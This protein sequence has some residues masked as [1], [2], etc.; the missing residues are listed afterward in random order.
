MLRYYCVEGFTNDTHAYLTCDQIFELGESIRAA[1]GDIPFAP[2]SRVE[3]YRPIIEPDLE[4]EPLP[5]SAISSK[6]RRPAVL[7]IVVPSYNSGPYLE[8]CAKHLLHQGDVSPEA[9]EVIFVDDGS[10]DNSAEMCSQL[11]ATRVDSPHL[12]VIRIER[13][14]PRTPGSAS[15]RAGVT[16]NV[17]A[18]YASGK[19]IAFVDADIIVSNG[20]IGRLLS[21][22]RTHDVVQAER[23]HLTFDAS[24]QLPLFE[25]VTES[26]CYVPEDGYWHDFYRDGKGLQWNSLPHAYEYVCSYCLAMPL[27]LFRDIGQFRRTFAYYGFE[28]TELGYRLWKQGAKF[29]LAPE[30]V[31]HLEPS[32]ARSE[33]ACSDA[34]RTELLRDSARW[35]YRLTLDRTVYRHHHGMM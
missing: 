19:W 4:L 28:D 3:P 12:S 20:F 26:D 7:S 33:F 35:F 10:N 1:Y 14:S 32:P 13:A 11:A 27:N 17:G 2:P 34:I 8:Q 15:F 6:V 29:F 23:H 9:Y 25:H 30:R 18:R 21:A 5:T 24:Q 22:L 16:R 31:Y